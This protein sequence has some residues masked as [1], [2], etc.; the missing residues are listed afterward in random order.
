MLYIWLASNQNFK[1]EEI[2]EKGIHKVN[3]TRREKKIRFRQFCP[4]FLNRTNPID[5]SM[6][7]IKTIP[8]Y[9]LFL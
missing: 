5:S 6:H 2:P 7:V 9:S 4:I 1:Y 8:F 3:G